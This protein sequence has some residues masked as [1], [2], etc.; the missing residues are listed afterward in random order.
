MTVTGSGLDASISVVLD[1][2]KQNLINQTSTLAYFTLVNIDDTKVTHVEVLTFEGYPAGV[3]NLTAIQLTP[4]LTSISPLD[5]SA[6]SSEILVSGTGFGL[7]T[8]GLNL[9]N[10]KTN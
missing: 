9:Y 8:T 6:G 5:G 3:G 7:Q 2:F 1:G 4:T 10:S